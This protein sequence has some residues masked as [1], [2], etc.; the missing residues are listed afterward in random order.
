MN[1]GVVDQRW[2]VRNSGSTALTA[3][4]PFSPSTTEEEIREEENIF[5]NHATSLILEQDPPKAEF[6]LH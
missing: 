2:G 5:E 3:S 6:A 1:A 4:A